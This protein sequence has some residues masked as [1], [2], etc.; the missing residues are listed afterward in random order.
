[1]IL[2]IFGIL[3]ILLLMFKFV[4]SAGLEKSDLEERYRF[5]LESRGELD[6]RDA[7]FR[8]SESW[9]AHYIVNSLLIR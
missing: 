8:N 5:L 1:M 7:I 4:P 6:P 3:L 2:T 9:E